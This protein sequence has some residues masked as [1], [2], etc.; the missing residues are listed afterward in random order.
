MK[1]TFRTYLEDLIEGMG[2]LGMFLMPKYY[3]LLRLNESKALS[4]DWIMVGSDM[5]KVLSKMS[6]EKKS[7]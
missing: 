7:E 5:H 1:R 4:Q 3:K 2:F 6:K